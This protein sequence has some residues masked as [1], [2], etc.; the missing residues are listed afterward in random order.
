[1]LAQILQL[2]GAEESSKGCLKFPEVSVRRAD[3][4]S[5]LFSSQTIGELKFLPVTDAVF[6][7]EM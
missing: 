3:G 2:P 6:R 4:H 5:D 1:M 7:A